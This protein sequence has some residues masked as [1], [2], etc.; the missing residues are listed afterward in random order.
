MNYFSSIDPYEDSVVHEAANV[1]NY[2][3][4]ERLG[5]RHTRNN[6]WLLDLDFRKRETCA[7]CCEAYSRLLD[8]E[9]KRTSRHSRLEA[10]ESNLPSDE[11][12]DP[13]AYIDVLREALS[14]HIGWKRVLSHC[15]P[16]QQCLR[17]TT[18]VQCLAK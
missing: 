3:K 10:A 16:T 17:A 5:L 9:D 13:D 6:E 15:T 11:R 18:A 7:Y 2:A 1:F 4:R 8:L 14:T 12:V